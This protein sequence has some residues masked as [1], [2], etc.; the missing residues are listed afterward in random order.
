MERAYYP[1][2]NDLPNL[3]ELIKKTLVKIRHKKTP[4]KG[5]ALYYLTA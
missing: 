1:T 2:L 3:C 4:P 5:E